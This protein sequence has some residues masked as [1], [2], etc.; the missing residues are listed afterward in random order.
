MGI[1]LGARKK[2]K[3]NVMARVGTNIAVVLLSV[4]WLVPFWLTGEYFFKYMNWID[5]TRTSMES[6]QSQDYPFIVSMAPFLICLYWFRWT[7]G[8][9]TIATGFWAFVVFSRLRKP[10]N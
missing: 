8:L 6:L 9:L 7:V 10:G 1:K 4:I 2:E 3:G 5:S